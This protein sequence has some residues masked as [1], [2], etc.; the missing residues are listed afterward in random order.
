MSPRAARRQPEPT[1]GKE[2][3]RGGQKGYGWRDQYSHPKRERIRLHSY[4]VTLLRLTPRSPNAQITAL[5]EN[6]WPFC[7]KLIIFCAKI[8]WPKNG[9]PKIPQLGQAR[10]ILVL[11]LDLPLR[12]GWARARWAVSGW[13]SGSGDGTT[14]Q[15]GGGPRVSARRKFPRHC[16]LPNPKCSLRLMHLCKIRASCVSIGTDCCKKKYVLQHFFTTTQ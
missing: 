11:S 8:A 14:V 12:Q 5:V 6:L 15:T 13:P 4:P 16:S 2:K 10:W 1:G 7:W 9:R 3:K